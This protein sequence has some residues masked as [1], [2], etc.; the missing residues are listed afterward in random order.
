MSR[1]ASL[2]LQRIPGLTAVL[3]I[4]LSALTVTLFPVKL[5]AQQQTFSSSAEYRSM[6]EELHHDPVRPSRIGAGTLLSTAQP[7]ADL[8][9]QDTAASL[10]IETALW[11]LEITKGHWGMALANKETGLT[12]Q[13]AGA[14]NSP[15]GIAWTQTSGNSS[16]L[17]LANIDRIDRHGDRW[18]MQVEVPGANAPATLEVAVLS[19]ASSACPSAHRILS[20]IQIWRRTSPER[21]PSSDWESVSTESNWTD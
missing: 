13:L 10:R 3:G 4:V 14:P 20:T 1:R 21:G 11:R 9:V 12:W 7:P 2:Q 17:P 19:P 8:Q 18:Q 5:A 15:A 16:T 6:L